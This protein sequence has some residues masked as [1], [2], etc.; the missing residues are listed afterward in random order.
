MPSWACPFALPPRFMRRMC[1][2][3]LLP[4]SAQDQEQTGVVENGAQRMLKI[5]AIPTAQ[6]GAQPRG[7]TIPTPICPSTINAQTHEYENKCS[8][9][10]TTQFPLHFGAPLLWQSLTD[11]GARESGLGKKQQGVYFHSKGLLTMAQRHSELPATTG[12]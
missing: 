9:L 10:F 6:L 12:G 2:R 11:K 7:S 4:L 5:P 3:E 8:L 1:P